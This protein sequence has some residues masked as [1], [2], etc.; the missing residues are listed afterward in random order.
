V[1]KL[2]LASFFETEK[3]G[4]GRSIGISPGKP[5]EAKECD[6]KFDA[7]SPGDL[8]WDYHKYKKDDP[9]IAGKAFEKAFRAQLDTFVK[10]VNAEAEKQ[11]KSVFDILPFKD[12]DTLLSWE[13]GGHMTYRVIVAEYLRKLGYEVEEN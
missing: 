5:K 3:W 6:L 2:V 9:E 11:N 13:K 10:E 4:P 1:P 8:Y 7:L 12:G